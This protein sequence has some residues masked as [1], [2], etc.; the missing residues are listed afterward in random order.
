MLRDVSPQQ[1]PEIHS[2]RVQAQD[3]FEEQVNK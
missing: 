1:L 2:L 3:N